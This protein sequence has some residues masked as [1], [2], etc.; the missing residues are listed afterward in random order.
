MHSTTKS[1]KENHTRMI[2]RKN[3]NTSKRHLRG[4]IVFKELKIQA[5]P[6]HDPYHAI[7]TPDRHTEPAAGSRG[8]ESA[9]PPMGPG[10]GL[11]AGR[12]RRYRSGRHRASARA[13]AGRR[14]PRRHGVDG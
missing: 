4:S 9:Y 7:R 11:P 10:T 1:T 8:A 5:K 6:C 2:K 14:S 3:Q 12:F 13:M